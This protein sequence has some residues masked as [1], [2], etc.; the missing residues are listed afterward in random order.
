MTARAGLVAVVRGLAVLA[1]SHAMLH[2]AGTLLASGEFERRG[3]RGLLPIMLAEPVTHLLVASAAFA[4]APWL[5]ARALPS[6]APLSPRALRTW[7]GVCACLVAV[8]LGVRFGVG[9]VAWTLFDP[10]RDV[11]WSPY[12]PVASVM[13]L[14]LCAGVATAAWV[15]PGRCGAAS[16]GVARWFDRWFRAS[17]PRPD[18]AP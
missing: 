1:A 2:I 7:A 11:G 5:A 14:V 10:Y 9:W 12:R 3:D 18:V 13:Q 8:D 16:R 4:A 17:R 15:G 6:D